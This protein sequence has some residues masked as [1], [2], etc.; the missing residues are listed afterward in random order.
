MLWDVSVLMDSGPFFLDEEAKARVANHPEGIMAG[1]EVELEHITS[2][3]SI[4]DTLA[5]RDRAVAEAEDVLAVIRK[6][7]TESREPGKQNGT[8]PRAED[9]GAPW[10]P[11]LT[12]IEER[13]RWLCDYTSLLRGYTRALLT[14]KRLQREGFGGL[15]P[16]DARAVGADSGSISIDEIVA[17]AVAIRSAADEIEVSFSRLPDAGTIADRGVYPFWS[18]NG[19]WH[20]PGA[21]GLIG[22]LRSTAQIVETLT[23]AE[24]TTDVGRGITVLGDPWAGDY[25]ESLFLPFTRA[26]SPAELAEG[27]IMVLGPEGVRRA[28]A[29]AG[30]ILDS[31]RGG[32]T[33]VVHL[34][35]AGAPLTVG[36][37][38]GGFG[39]YLFSTDEVVVADTAHPITAGLHRVRSQPVPIRGKERPPQAIRAYAGGAAPWHPLTYPA[40]LLECELGAGRI[41]ANLV[42]E[43]RELFL[44][45]VAAGL[46]Q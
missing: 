1:M 12:R 45:C 11:T 8:E 30:R 36:W 4:R 43:N 42:P 27:R 35:A 2:P 25:F 37:L 22:S 20:L 29:D 44:R 14:L 9:S 15:P 17:P 39:L 31:V 5:L 34:A 24:G 18:E 32:A 33:L 16:E 26:E 40:V 23:A 10:A 38:P 21:A 28:S 6:L 19:P 7:M 13:C 41:I 46:R 3:E